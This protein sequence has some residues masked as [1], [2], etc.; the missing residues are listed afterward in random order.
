MAILFRPAQ[1]YVIDNEQRIS[2]R[3][4]VFILFLLLVLLSIQKVYAAQ[5]HYDRLDVWSLDQEGKP[6]PMRITL[7]QFANYLTSHKANL[8]LLV[9]DTDLL[10]L[11]VADP[12]MNLHEH[13][14]NTYVFELI[15]DKN[16][17]L[18]NHFLLN[19]QEMRGMDL[20]ANTTSLFQLVAGQDK[21]LQS[22][23]RFTI[24]DKV[25]DQTISASNFSIPR[26]NLKE[27]EKI[28]GKILVNLP[29]SETLSFV[30]LDQNGRNQPYLYL[31]DNCLIKSTRICARIMPKT[32]AGT[33]IKKY[34]ILTDDL[35]FI[36]QCYPF[37]S[38]D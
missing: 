32:H 11:R 17:V 28:C 4:T 12:R 27:A 5:A 36:Q 15:P 31:P 34:G 10:E 25:P 30:L 37:K 38:S 16:I 24:I 6:I 26:E 2:M 18:C 1:A 20:Y 14:I 33:Q 7:G 22:N 23:F 29:V 35:N 9:M 21:N 13:I 8:T 3:K 19:G